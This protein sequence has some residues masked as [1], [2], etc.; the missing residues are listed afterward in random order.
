MARRNF[1]DHV[2]P[3]GA[4]IGA[5][6]VT[7]GYNFG[8]LGE[9]I[10]AGQASVAEVMADWLESD[11]HCNNIMNRTFTEVAVACVSTNRFEYPTYWTME[12]GRPR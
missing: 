6:A 7:V 1:F 2:N 12:L 9:N 5:R 3:D 8:A 11:G 10:A 4:D